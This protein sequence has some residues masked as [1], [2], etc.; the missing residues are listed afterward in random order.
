MKAKKSFGQNFLTDKNIVRKIVVAAEVGPGDLVLEI[1]P[2][3]GILTEA[4]LGVGARV[5]AVE[6]DED[7]IEP[8]KEKFDSRIDLIHGD[9]LSEIVW[10]KIRVIVGRKKYS[11]VA[12]IPYNITSPIIEM[13]F[14]AEPRPERLTLMV[15]REVADRL[16]AVPPRTSVLSIA[17]QLYAEGKKMMQVKRGAFTPAPKV[18]STV[19]RLDLRTE[20]LG[21]VDPE[22]VLKIVKA[23]FSARRKQLHGNLAKAKI[24]SSEKAKEILKKITL[25]EK[26]RAEN[27]T[28]EEWIRLFLSLS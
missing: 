18:D 20:W 26:S 4:L 11:I 19:V 24:C 5:I 6:A 13:L 10:K 22:A 9:I 14:R 16:L 12:N 15:Q 27:L 1:G 8:L 21:S 23:G 7:L 25:N 17:C 28:P 2:G 3:Q